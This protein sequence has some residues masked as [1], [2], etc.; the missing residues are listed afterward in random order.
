MIF[1][2]AAFIFDFLTN[3]LSISIIYETIK[4]SKWTHSNSKASFCQTLDCYNQKI[5]WIVISRSFLFKKIILLCQLNNKTFQ[6]P[7][8]IGPIGFAISFKLIYV[9]HCLKTY[10]RFDF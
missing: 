9:N 5:I 7:L 1:K 3:E 10:C 4:C 6:T 8:V 2:N